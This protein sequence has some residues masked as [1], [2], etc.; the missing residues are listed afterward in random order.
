MG[1]LRGSEGTSPE[2]LLTHLNVFQHA[3]QFLPI[4]ELP[5][6]TMSFVVA[7]VRLEMP[8]DF[9][10]DRRTLY[11]HHRAIRDPIQ[12]RAEEAPARQIAPH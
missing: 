12:C 3:G 4:V 9:S 2:V 6:V 8:P 5:A 11:R 10:Y 7:Q 1:Q